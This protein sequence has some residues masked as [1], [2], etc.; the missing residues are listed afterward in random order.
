[1]VYGAMVR[2]V[3]SMSHGQ[4]WRRSRSQAMTASRRAIGSRGS[5]S[6]VGRSDAM[7]LILNSDYRIIYIMTNI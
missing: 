6:A 4:P 2:K 1:M 7:T 5:E 3:W